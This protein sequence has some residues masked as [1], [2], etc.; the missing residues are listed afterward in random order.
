[1]EV[2]WP[3]NRCIICLQEG[4]LTAEHIIPAQIGGKLSVPVLCKPCNDRLGY[5]VEAA[6]KSDPAIRCAVEHLKEE[7]PDVAKQF[8][9]GQTYLGSGEGGL[10]R[11]K[12]KDGTF[13]V[14]AGRKQ[15]GSIIQP[16][17]DG[18]DHVSKVLQKRG[19]D[20]EDRETILQQ[21]D[22]APENQ[23]IELA[24]GLAAIKW[25]IDTIEPA[26]GGPRLPERVLLKIAYEFV[27][28]HLGAKVYEQSAQLTDI[29]R[30]LFEQ[31][32]DTHIYSV[33]Y[34]T[35]RKYAPIHRI[36]LAGMSPHVVVTICLF[37]WLLFRVHFQRIA[38]PPPNYRYSCNLDNGE[39]FFE[40]LNEGSYSGC[41][42]NLSLCGNKT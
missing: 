36:A 4:N 40:V 20:Q 23:R 14:N 37:G 27:A 22:Q 8:L 34:L 29:R 6:V 35:T 18:R 10:V 15:D 25:R 3:H 2:R 11:G 9:E 7:I 38:I 26:L 1:M 39:E 41:G 24:P 30:A 28:C 19:V 33:E 21:F 17:P 31:S 32:A 12:V 42:A 13:R 16:T 5:Q